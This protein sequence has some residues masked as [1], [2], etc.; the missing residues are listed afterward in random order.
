MSFI[1]V[2]KRRD[3]LAATSTGK[4]FITKSIILQMV[5]RTEGHPD[6]LSISRIGFTVT[7]KMG[8]AVIRNSIKRRL[9]EAARPALAKHG[10]AGH[11]Y[12]V[13][14]RNLALTCEFSDLVRDMEFAFT[15]IIHHKNP[16]KPNTDKK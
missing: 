4:K 9:R 8:N 13:I 15:R 1:T 16:E 3:F 11:D 14:S 7:K 5:A 6:G 2:K 12:V 10:V